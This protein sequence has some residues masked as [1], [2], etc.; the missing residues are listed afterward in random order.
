MTMVYQWKHGSR[1][2]LDPQAAGEELERIRTWNNGR[3][4]PLNVVEAS[5]DAGAPL[6]TAFEWDDGKAA[7]SWRLEQARYVI[8]SVEVIVPKHSGGEAPI[9]AFV[10]VERDADRSYTSVHHALS[11]KELR[12]QVLRQAWADLEAWRQRN[13]E[14][15]E[16]AE[17]FAMIDQ[18]RDA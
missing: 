4:E 1:I 8:R 9:R 7:Q 18:A 17:I 10:S 3:L 16:F 2:D 5:R 6:H 13:A 14:L 12:V 15:V 11:D